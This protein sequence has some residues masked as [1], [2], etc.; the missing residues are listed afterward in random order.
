MLR[1]VSTAS[2]VRWSC[3]I[4]MFACS[5]ARAQEALPKVEPVTIGPFAD[6]IVWPVSG[7]TKPDTRL[8]RLEQAD[9]IEKNSVLENMGKKARE[10]LERVVKEHPGTPWASAAQQ[11]LA[12]PIGWKWIES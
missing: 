2:F 4:A 12:A 5:N 8:W 1:F 7:S 3:L 6:E 11:E 10:Y 9:G